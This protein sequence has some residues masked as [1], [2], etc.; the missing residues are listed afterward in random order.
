MHEPFE[1]RHSGYCDIC[2][3]NVEFRATE[4]WFRDHLA[5]TG[6]NSI[7]RERALMQV[8][9]H[10]YPN[11]RKLRIHESSPIERGVSARLFRDAKHYSSSQFIPN[12]PLGA[13][14]PRFNTRCE[15]LEALTFTDNSFDLIVTQD[16]MEHIPSPDLAFREICRVLKPGG[17][18]IFTV[19]L[20]RK[21]EPSRR[22]AVFT[23]DGKIE[24]L[25]APEY[26]G[27]PVDGSGSLVV[28]DW[29]FDI[30]S[31]ISEACGMSSHIIAIDDIDRGIRA[32][33][34]EV[35]VSLKR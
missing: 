3:K 16:V 4:R 28:M 29:G 7:P 26:H 9:K 10:Y 8:L 20:V 27:N 5:C 24:H 1:F 22:R 30:I 21:G 17:A 31:K 13:H 35:V 6:C 15:S 34:I 2:E 18:H 11:F 14:D 12:T 25:F 33:F 32:E 19:P 23:T